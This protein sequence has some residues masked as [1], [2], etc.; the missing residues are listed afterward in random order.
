MRSF[1]YCQPSPGAEE[2]IASAHTVDEIAEKIGADSLSYLSLEGMLACA[3]EEP[4]DYC[5][6]CFSKEYPV[7]PEPVD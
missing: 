3:A 4:G 2:L 5:H 1:R 6:A 7:H